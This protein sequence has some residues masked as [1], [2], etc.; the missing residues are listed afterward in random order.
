MSVVPSLVTVTKPS[1]KRNWCWPEIVKFKLPESKS[2]VSISPE[3]RG[4]NGI[5]STIEDVDV[6]CNGFPYSSKRKTVNS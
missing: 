4:A 1:A 6:V 3:T 2:H 5:I